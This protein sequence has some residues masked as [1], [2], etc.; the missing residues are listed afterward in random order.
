MS[1]GVYV[2]FDHGLRE[3]LDETVQLRAEANLAF[4]DLGAEPPVLRATGDPGQ[5]RAH[6]EAV[7]RLFGADGRLL[8]DASPAAGGAPGELD[9]VKAAVAR[10][11]PVMRT[12]DYSDSETFRIE[13][14][15]VLADG[16]VRAVLVTGVERSAVSEPLRV[17]ATILRVAVPLAAVALGAGAFFIA[18]RALAPVAEITATARR[19]A[20]G[21]LRG[22][23]GAIGARDEVGELASAFNEMIDR[24][25][26]TV[27][28]ERRFTADASHELRTPLTAIETSLEVTLSQER[29]TAQYREALESVKAN[30]ARMSRLTR[31]LLLLSRLDADAMRSDFEQLDLDGLVAA[32][33][34]EFRDAHPT[35]QVNLQ[36]SGGPLPLRGNLELLARAFTNVLEN[37]LVH[38]GPEVVISVDLAVTR[39]R[40]TVR[41]HDTGPGIPAE[42]APEIFQR[43]RRGD[44]ARSGGGSGLGLAIAERIVEAHGGS[45]SVLPGPGA[46]FAFDFPLEQAG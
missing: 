13:A 32:V 36:G 25:A 8:S 39:A 38:A 23:I 37:A 1:A 3:N 45:I 34:A 31:Q 6:G 27:E 4:V 42:L 21:D 30:A 5:E 14:I 35:A 19:I 26:E 40:A 7:L 16:V 11:S 2:A 24:V 15:P 33:V 18:R 9:A 29:T 28:R 41:I 17:L 44:S 46:T 43:F 10:A 20:D 22:R 12:L